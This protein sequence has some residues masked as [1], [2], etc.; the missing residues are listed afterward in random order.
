M[1][2]FIKETGETK[3]LSIID[4]KS[5]TEWTADLIGNSGDLHYNSEEDRYEMQTEADFDWWKN[6]IEGLSNIDNLT[7]QARVLLTN[8][9]FEILEQW[10]SE[11][12]NACDY[13]QHIA[14]ITAELQAVIADKS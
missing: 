9:D 3:K 4:R 13:E 1:E 10:V 2:F 11:N 5:N 8:D 6:T 7:E 12:G 14:V